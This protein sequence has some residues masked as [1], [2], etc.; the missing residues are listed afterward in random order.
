[1]KADLSDLVSFKFQLSGVDTDIPHIGIIALTKYLAGEEYNYSYTRHF[2]VMIMLFS[3]GMAFDNSPFAPVTINTN[4]LLRS[5]I[6]NE[7]HLLKM[8]MIVGCLDLEH[9]ESMQV[10]IE[11]LKKLMEVDSIAEFDKNNFRSY[12]EMIQ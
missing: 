12:S 2:D 7:P 10:F 1:M 4:N 11:P 6:K 8:C 9:L 3:Y 5:L